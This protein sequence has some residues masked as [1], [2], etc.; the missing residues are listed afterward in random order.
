MQISCALAVTLAS[1]QPLQS[2]D[3]TLMT[4]VHGG[5]KLHL[6]STDSKYPDLVDQWWS[7]LLPRIAPYLQQNGGPILMVQ[8]SSFSHPLSAG[9]FYLHAR[10]LVHLPA[11][12]VKASRSVDA[13]GKL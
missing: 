5:G 2:A 13:Q 10:L 8:A 7:V 11:C 3:F 6:R 1:D 4:Q 12:L 9:F